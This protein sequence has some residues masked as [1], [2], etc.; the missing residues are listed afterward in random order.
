MRCEWCKIGFGVLFVLV[1]V[2]IFTY[3]F[4]E[5]AAP[6]N[7]SIATGRTDGAYYQYALRYQ[8]LLKDE[9]F[10]LEI[11]PTSGSVEALQLLNE[12]KIDV[13]FV[14]GGAASQ[15]DTSNLMTLGSVYFEPLWIFYRRTIS[16][17][18]IYDLKGS[19]I[20]IGSEGSG[21]RALSL[22]L[23]NENKL[24]D[25]NTT[26]LPLS[27]DDAIKALK[28]GEIDALFSV[29]SASSP[30]ITELL[31][32]PNIELL[33]MRRALAYEKRMHYLKDLHLG[34]GSL[35][36]DENLPNQS[37]DIL[38]TTATLVVD[39]EIHPDSI[40][41][42]LKA[43]KE[44]H[45]P[46]STFAQKDQ[47]PTR[48]F[49]EIEMSE[50]AERYILKGESFL[51]RHLPFSLAGTVD[52][53]LIMI[54]PLA[55]L[56]FPLFKGAMPLYRWRVRSKI[57]KWYKFVRSIDLLIEK[58]NETELTT[59]LKQIE[60]LDLEVKKDSDIPLSYMGEYYELRVHIELIDARLREKIKLVR[61][62]STGDSEKETSQ[63]S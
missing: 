14:Q 9:G 22:Q 32:D 34:E 47:F 19:H 30:H 38:G 43:A 45:S 57:Y 36:L 16:P 25:E 55:T 20:A 58:M 41:L 52:R 46:A 21:T 39:K 56:I 23:L 4:I 27:G 24:N 7:I 37:I 6:K 42:L 49:T 54:I 40:R 53:L 5:P 12:K 50:D 51:E 28:A 18:Y 10:E 1:A 62:N 48:D 13:A 63:A 15:V 26:L 11:V 44:I 60:D 17:T 59:S 29:I 2:S 3:Q 31:R 35:D 33:E 8:E 61:K